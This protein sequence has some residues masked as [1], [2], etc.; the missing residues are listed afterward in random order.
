MLSALDSDL[1]FQ[2]A[3]H[4]HFINLHNVQY[5]KEE[6]KCKLKGTVDIPHTWSV[7]WNLENWFL[8]QECRRLGLISNLVLVPNYSMQV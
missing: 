6:Q 5:C 7:K 3:N 1:H 8:G 4:K 2:H